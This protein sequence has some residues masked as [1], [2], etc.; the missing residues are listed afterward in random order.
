MSSSSQIIILYKVLLFENYFQYLFT[1]SD[2]TMEARFIFVGIYLILE[3]IAMVLCVSGNLIVVYVMIFKK[4]LVKSTHL[5]IVSVAFADLLMGLVAITEGI[6]I[7]SLCRE[8][9]ALE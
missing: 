7:V 1:L 5:F 9:Y 6:L 8:K 3:I 2:R 4:K